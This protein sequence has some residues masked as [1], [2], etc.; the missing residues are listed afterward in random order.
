MFNTGTHVECDYGYRPVTSY[1]IYHGKKLRWSVTRLDDYSN[2]YVLTY[3]ETKEVYYL[4]ESYMDALKEAI[5]IIDDF[6]SLK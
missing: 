5:F 2:Q 6:L 1:L 4:K 3:C